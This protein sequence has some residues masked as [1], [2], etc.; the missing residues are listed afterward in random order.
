MLLHFTFY[1]L[2]SSVEKCSQHVF[3]NNIFIFKVKEKY[4]KLLLFTIFVEMSFAFNCFSD[5]LE[6][7]Q[8]S[9]VSVDFCIFESDRV[10]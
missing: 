9:Q 10:N 8:M 2:T 3:E 7:L 4:K 6:G 1:H 5:F